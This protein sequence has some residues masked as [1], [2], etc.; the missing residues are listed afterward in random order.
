MLATK[1]FRPVSRFNRRGWWP[2]YWTVV[3]RNR[4]WMVINGNTGA[5]VSPE[6]EDETDAMI[7]ADCNG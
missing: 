5:Q 3:R 6:F 4:K 2:D 1:K 7:W